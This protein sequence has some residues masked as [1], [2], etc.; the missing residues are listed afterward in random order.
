MLVRRHPLVTYVLLT[1]GV[2]WGGFLAALGL[3][4]LRTTEWQAEGR[5]SIAI[6][7]ML[8]GP[9]AAGLLLTGVVDGRAGYR[10]LGLRLRRWRVGTGW[11]LVAVAP[12]PILSAA[13]VLALSTPFPLLGGDRTAVLLGGLGAGL[14]TVLE[15]IGWTGFAVAHLRRRC[16]EL[17]TGLVVGAIWGAWHLLQQ[18]FIL[19][20]Y[21]GAVPRP[22]FFVASVAA[23]IA[24]LT[25]VRI[26]LVWLHDRTASVLLTT[27]LHG[28]LTASSIFWFTPIATGGRFLAN[29][30]LAAAAWWLVAAAV[31]AFEGWLRIGHTDP[32]RDASGRIRPESI[33]EAGFWRIGGVDQ[34]VMVRG[35]DIANPVLVVLHGGPGMSETGFFRR[36]NA[37]LES[38][39]TV[40]HWEQRGA[41]KSFSRDLPVASMTVARFLDDLDELVDRVR[42]RLGQAKVVLLGHSWGSALGVLY[43]A[44]HPEKVAVYVGAGQV[45]DWAAAEAASYAYGLAEA[46]RQG[47]ASALARLR[48]LGPPPHPAHHVFVER[49]IVN[50]L[51]GQ[52]RPRILWNATRALFHRPESSLFD[53]PSLLRGFRFSLEAM[54]AEVSALNLLQLVPDLAMP[55]FVVVGR[56]DHWVPPEMSVAY[57]DAVSAPSKTLLWF[58]HSGHE[59]FVDEP[60][61]FNAVLEER[62]RP[63]ACQ[64]DRQAAG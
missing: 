49:S 31:A 6:V 26:V 1:F 23:S 14:S 39:F 55:V 11:W 20:T 10:R 32:F 53:L 38:C 42:Q 13:V 40:V 61:R 45:G 29:V 22:V 41:G 34:W 37:P 2:S 35:A 58:D 46:E 57:F 50:R 60:A 9:A 44:R 48:A 8:V 52:M 25:A 3:E 16:S 30:W 19:G 17:R 47:D 64:G 21:A 15:E 4:G 62:V 51:D 59:A 56:R 43:A 63:L 7:A 27:V 33:A 54:W 36:F 28:M 5:T 18:V 12:A 24:S